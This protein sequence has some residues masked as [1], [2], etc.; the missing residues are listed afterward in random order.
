MHIPT[1]YPGT[2]CERGVFK[3]PCMGE[4]G[5][6]ILFAVTSERKLLGNV[7]TVIPWGSDLNAAGE[8]LFA[9]LDQLDHLSDERADL[10]RR[11]VIRAV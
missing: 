9:L 7:V 5:E 6:I 8:A 4:H 2:M 1:A 11:R 3:L 10:L